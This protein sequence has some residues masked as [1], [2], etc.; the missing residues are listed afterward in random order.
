MTVPDRDSPMARSS[1]MS[2][3]S[4][5]DS[6][7]ESHH[8]SMRWARPGRTSVLSAQDVADPALGVD[9]LPGGPLDG[10]LAP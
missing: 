3:T 10:E 7:L 1:V 6:G 8:A 4:C 2:V 5:A 9:Q